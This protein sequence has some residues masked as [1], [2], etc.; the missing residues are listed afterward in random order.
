MP[1]PIGG[2]DAT[3]AAQAKLE[4]EGL[5]AIAI[6]PPTVPDGEA[7][8]RLSFSAAHSNEDVVEA[9]AALGTPVI[10]LVHGW[11]Y[12]ASFWDRCGRASAIALHSIS[13]FLA[14]ATRRSPMVS[15]CWWVIPWASCGCC[16]NRRWRICR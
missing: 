12:D 15:R 11:G 2:N 6:R 7:R 4:A 1:L 13:A 9:T 8:L 5:L 16:G 10:L 14:R 3:L